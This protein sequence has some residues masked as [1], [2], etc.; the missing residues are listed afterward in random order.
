MAWIQLDF[1]KHFLPREK[2]VNIVT[3]ADDLIV[4]LQAGAKIMIHCAGEGHAL[5]SAL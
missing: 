4:R 5:A 1:W 3:L 2:N